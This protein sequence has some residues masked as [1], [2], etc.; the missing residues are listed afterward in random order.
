MDS[1][2]SNRQ[3][4]VFEVPLKSPLPERF[5]PLVQ[6]AF[7]HI[8][9]LDRIEEVYNQVSQRQDD[10]A[11]VDKVLQTLGVECRLNGPDL[12]RI[13]LGGKAV[14]VA[15]HPFGLIDGVALA[16]TLCTVRPDVK[17]LGNF[18]LDQITE[19]RDLLISVDPFGATGSAGKNVKG[20][21]RAIDWLRCGH[22]LAVFPAGEVAHLDLRTREVAD[23]DWSETIARIIRLTESPVLP[24]FF[25]GANGLAFQLLGL[26]HPLLRTAML[27]HEALNKRGKELGIKIG[28]V[29]PF[30]ALSKHAT[31]SEMIGYLRRRL[32]MLRY[33][34][35]RSSLPDHR[36]GEVSSDDSHGGAAMIIKRGPSSRAR[37]PE[38]IA[39]PQESQRL[40]QEVRCLPVEQLLVRSVGF[41]VFC[42]SAAQTPRL[43]CE[44]GRLREIAFRAAG[45]G[46]GRAIDLDRFDLY[47]D[48]LILW[49]AEAGEIAGAYRIGKVDEIVAQ[50]GKKGLYTGTLFEYDTRLLD[51]LG[52]ALELGR[53]FVKPEYQRAVVPLSLLWKG[54]AH[55]VLRRPR[56]RVLFGTVSISNDYNSASKHLMVEFL[57]NHCYDDRLASLVRAKNPFNSGRLGRRAG[58]WSGLVKNV[59]DLSAVVSDIE[60]DNRSIPVLI[61]QYLKLGGRL[62]GFNLDHTFGDSLDGLMIIDLVET[63]PKI[64]ER[65]MGRDEAAEFL[66]YHSSQTAVCA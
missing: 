39:P 31:D 63:D 20:L 43:L 19:L 14:V 23:P 11:F 61:R 51:D 45:E 54:I 9:Q 4:L 2:H 60:P 1:I 56:Y 44:I 26:V 50:F 65:Y 55:Y 22:V 52:P 32:H 7:K 41:E 3:N 33:R 46:T 66:S 8:L 42:A 62:I 18:L 40:L 12:S 57:S 10:T 37:V 49:N 38:P 16:R 36:Y 58:D 64:L 6:S 28:N 15:N 35:D 27:P 29:I 47:Y 24:V 59:E 17:L 53:A 5:T 25:E 48:H 34:P 13:P 21:K 30:A